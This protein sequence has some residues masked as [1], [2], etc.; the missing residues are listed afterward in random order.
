TQETRSDYYKPYPVV[1]TNQVNM[2][3]GTLVAVGA[4]F[5]T[6]VLFIAC[7]FYVSRRED[8]TSN[9]RRHPVNLGYQMIY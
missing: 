1:Y 3:V 5:G 8:R 9:G 7:S 4:V 6:L 2:I